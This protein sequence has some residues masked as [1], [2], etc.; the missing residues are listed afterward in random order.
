M[1]KRPVLVAA[2]L[3]LA[4]AGVV[5]GS[6]LPSYLGSADAG[7]EAP[8]S[9][10]VPV[11]ESNADDVEQDAPVATRMRARV[12]VSSANG[13]LVR[14]RFRFPRLL[15]WKTSNEGSEEFLPVSICL[16]DG[17]VVGQYRLEFGGSDRFEARVRRSCRQ[18]R[19]AAPGFRTVTRT[20]P[21]SGDPVDLGEVV[22]VPRSNVVVR[23][24]S[25]PK[26]PVEWLRIAV[27]REDARP[28][29][30]A[31]EPISHIN[32][33]QAMRETF[34]RLAGRRTLWSADR[35]TPT[36]SMT[37]RVA[38]PSGNRI[39]VVISD[40]VPAGGPGL[41]FRPQVF[42]PWSLAQEESRNVTL[43]FDRLATTAGRVTRVPT[44]A[45]LRVVAELETDDHVDHVAPAGC[46]W[47]TVTDSQGRF[48]LRGL[49]R[50]TLH[51]ELDCDDQRIPLVAAGDARDSWQTPLASPLSVTP[52]EPLAGV[53]LLKGGQPVSLP[54]SIGLDRVAQRDAA[55]AEPVLFK[56]RSLREAR[57]LCLYV[58][59]IG[60]F[61]R[62][63]SE[64]AVTDDGTVPVE[65]PDRLGSLLVRYPGASSAPWTLVARA[66]DT[67]SPRYP[68]GL[69]AR[70]T[71]DGWL[72]EGLD[73]GVYV[74]RWF[75]DGQ[76]IRQTD[77]PGRV[78]ITDGKR[79]EISAQPPSFESVR[80][81][82]TNWSKIPRHLRPELLGVSGTRWPIEDGVAKVEVP[83][84]IRR[85]R[86]VDFFSPSFQPSVRAE[87]SHD[88]GAAP[89]ATVEFPID[90]LAIS[91]RVGARFGG[92]VGLSV[93]RPVSRMG[94]TL[95]ASVEPGPEGTFTLAG[96]GKPI[97]GVVWESTPGD[98]RRHVRG[99][100][101]LEGTRQRLVLNPGG[102]WVTLHP[103]RVED[104]ACDVHLRGPDY[105]DERWIVLPAWS[106][107]D[108]ETKIWVPEPTRALVFRGWDGQKLVIPSRRLTAE[109]RVELPR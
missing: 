45:P 109:V 24:L 7:L 73:A 27:I 102:R 13:R 1:S 101:E 60:Y 100:F 61:S 42:G 66:P 17:S 11:R 77:Q 58:Q 96:T 39:F 56:R 4:T 79:T 43:D 12:G 89:G 108:Q 63:T 54:H 57:R 3:I 50:G 8:G 72:W 65:L 87:V 23:I 92:K 76:R 105:I 31:N 62:A 14:M 98:G 83:R 74:L 28:D 9:E 10:P 47:A 94:L 106:G 18:L 64:L 36:G 107:L 44:T 97:R 33:G 71:E 25:A 30:D 67:E 51:L 59:G 48:H 32:A 84:P 55:D 29:A 90:E 37:E 103:A 88:D 38:V 2:T 40:A 41:G 15:P 34:A 20:L 81:E 93:F 75:H 35:A 85:L 80:V 26:T 46:A 6:L 70:A 104:S 52:A 95:A 78:A 5:T 21:S 91:V 22:F 49:P 69:V 68:T 19:F 16:Q 82:V 86:C 53:I 99:W